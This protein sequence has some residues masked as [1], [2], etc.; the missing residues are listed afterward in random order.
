MA[1]RRREALVAR[2]EHTRSP[3]C[4]EAHA[5]G[6]DPWRPPLF[7]RSVAALQYQLCAIACAGEE[8]KG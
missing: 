4:R 1:E 7:E 5:G 3:S 6:G 8:E 2:Q